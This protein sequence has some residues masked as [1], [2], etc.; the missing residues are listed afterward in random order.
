M[1]QLAYGLTFFLLAT[2]LSSTEV[3]AQQPASDADYYYDKG[4]L[5]KAFPIY[6][7]NANSLNIEQQERLGLMYLYGAGAE[8]NIAQGIEWLKKAANGG[9]NSSKGFLG[10]LYYSGEMVPQNVEEGLRLINEAVKSGDEGSMSM[11]G[12][13]YYE[14]AHVTKD[15]SKAKALF[16]E[17]VKIAENPSAA[18]SLYYMYSNGEGVEKDM[19]EAMRYL[20]IA[21]KGGDIKVM[22]LLAKA[23]E[24]GNGLVKDQNEALKWYNKVWQKGG[25]Q[26]R[27]D[28]NRILS[29]YN[30]PTGDQVYAYI[31]GIAIHANSSFSTVLGE[32]IGKEKVS[33]PHTIT[34]YSYNS[35]GLPFFK[36]PTVTV[37]E[38]IGDAE[39]GGVKYKKGQKTRA[40]HAYL[41]DMTDERTA[42]N[43]I[44][45]WKRL[46]LANFP[47][48]KL[49]EDKENGYVHF[50]GMIPF[51]GG[52]KQ[53]CSLR[54][55][56]KDG[57]YFVSIEME[58]YLK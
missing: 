56:S 2:S 9:R 15:Y 29:S 53:L 14:G 24:E 51:T 35:P 55:A 19:K 31:N 50:L 40:F 28:I 36:N 41:I 48:L 43:V 47:G 44:N 1:K 8:K 17:S 58:H 49:M 3:I 18:Y 7:K 46:I 32:Q 38:C 57:N 34:T 21:A 13:I 22:R 20:K 30:A 45:E 11:L 33:L 10:Y 6:I 16:I 5:D 37:R 54:K 52:S 4:Q 26:Y 42:E 12:S 23:Y 25:N 27:K 39:M